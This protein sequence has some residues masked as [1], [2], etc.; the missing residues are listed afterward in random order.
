MI[1]ESPVK[2]KRFFGVR[3]LS[4][5]FK[6]SAFAALLLTVGALGYALVEFI[7]LPLHMKT[8][9]PRET[10]VWALFNYMVGI[11]AVGG[12]SALFFYTIALVLEMLLSL[13]ESLHALARRDT[14]QLAS[15]KGLH[16]SNLELAH[17]IE[18]LT[19]AVGRQERLT[20]LAVGGDESKQAENQ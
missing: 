11:I 13:N 12:I 15:D 3:M 8:G 16:S 19:E 9:N 2:V 10:G 14:A 18:K 5:V 4:L 7:G 17:R 20:R 1:G 6:V